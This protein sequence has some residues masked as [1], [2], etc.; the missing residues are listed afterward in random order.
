MSSTTA[1]TLPYAISTAAAALYE[2]TH[3]NLPITTANRE[4]SNDTLVVMLGPSSVGTVAIQLAMASG[5]RVIGLGTKQDLEPIQRLGS[6]VA[7]DIDDENAHKMIFSAVESNRLVGILD[8]VSSSS[9][10]HL[11]E[12]LLQ[13]PGERPRICCLRPFPQALGNYHYT[14]GQSCK[15]SHPNSPSPQRSQVVYIADMLENKALGLS[16]LRPLHDFVCKEVWANRV[17]ELLCTGTL[18]EKYAPHIAGTGLEAAG[19]V[20]QNAHCLES[21]Q[22]E[23]VVQI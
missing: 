22:R 8:T 9:S 14:I 20:M 10:A 19:A 6:D 4:R 12:A 2:K 11:T 5:L 16:I 3:L 17:P 13:L 15:S 21:L 1:A 23:M 7:I 18:R